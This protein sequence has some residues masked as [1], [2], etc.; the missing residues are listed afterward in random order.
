MHAHARAV[1]ANDCAVPASHKMPRHRARP[2]RPR[3]MDA[4]S[5]P[6]DPS[7]SVRC[8]VCRLS[9]YVQEEWLHCLERL[10]ADMA[11][12]DGN[13]MPRGGGD[14]DTRFDTRSEG[15]AAQVSFDYGGDRTCG[16]PNVGDLFLLASFVAR[17][18]RLEEFVRLR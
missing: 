9:P 8:S 15:G 6:D 18:M 10:L 3:C 7:S 12:D 17:M 11:D 13:I 2:A 1:Q 14:S 16:I 4:W 5:G